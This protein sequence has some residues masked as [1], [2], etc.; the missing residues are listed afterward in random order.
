MKVNLNK[1]RIF[2][3]IIFTA[4]CVLN[5]SGCQDEIFNEIRDEIELEDSTVSGH[6]NSIVRYQSGSTEYIVTQNGNLY[7]RPAETA[8]KNDKK[9]QKHN[10]IDQSFSHTLQYAIRK[11]YT[12]FHHS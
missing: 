6:I 1:N 12:S 4:F 8:T 2:L 3:T 9:S 7:Y 5:F 11:R 10:K